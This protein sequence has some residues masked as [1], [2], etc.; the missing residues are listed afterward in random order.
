MIYKCKMCGGNIE[1]SED[2]TFGTCMY[3]GCAMTF[4]KLDDEQRASMFNR[5]NHFRRIG[6][7]DSAVAVYEQLILED[8]T[9]AEAHWC[10]AISRFGIEYVEDPE[11]YEW[12]PT[13]HRL[14]F[15]PF[16]KDV[17]Y[18]AALEYSEGVTQKQ[19]MRDAAKISEVQKGILKT[20]Q[21]E[22]PFDIFICYK[23]S[24]DNG[25]RTED[26]VMAQEVYYKLTDRGYR[27]FFSRIT[28]EDKVGTEFEP[29]IFAALNSAKVMIVIGTRR[30]YLNAVWVKN[31]WSRF[32]AIIR[33]DRDK[34]ILPCY[35]DMD[36]YDMPEALAVLQ[37]YDMSKIG[38]IQDLIHGISKIVDNGKNRNNKDFNANGVAYQASS[39][40]PLLKRTRLFLEDGDFKKADEYCEIVLNLDPENSRAY[41]Y[42]A[43]AKAGVT[44]ED[45]LIQLGWNLKT[46]PNFTKALR[47]AKDAEKTELDNIVE[48]AR[49]IDNEKMYQKAC[50]AARETQDLRRTCEAYRLFGELS[51]YKDSNAQR[52]NLKRDY[53]DTQYSLVTSRMEAAE[54]YDEMIDLLPVCEVLLSIYPALKKYFDKIK[55][56][57]E[58]WTGALE[59]IVYER[60]KYRSSKALYEAIKN[61]CPHLF[62]TKRHEDFVKELDKL[63]YVEKLYGNTKETTIKLIERYIS[64][65]PIK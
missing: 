12:V 44:T 10:C 21:N 42:K 52:E 39:V 49:S 41:L 15:E 18:L 33:K 27:V 45:G 53:L 54:H 3:C 46:D 19:Y 29:Y 58:N 63:V 4:P 51:G 37:C 30:E 17:D 22:A 61:K 64:G 55:A 31:E 47:F 2:R 1:L 57:E 11:T 16:V 13:C 34:V 32:L 50:E 43:M 24:A 48:Q 14:S 60:S 56:F 23:E 35:K 8:N 26:S 25:E 9:D 20:S 65:E 6:D 40:G 59:K 62:V 5:G 28:L 38:F 7:F 36:P